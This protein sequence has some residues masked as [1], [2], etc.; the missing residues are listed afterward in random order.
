MDE[1]SAVSTLP[2]TGQTMPGEQHPDG[3]LTANL[4]RAPINRHFIGT[5]IL[6]TPGNEVDYRK[7][8]VLDT[9][10]ADR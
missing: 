6:C 5:V 10:M 1:R 8:T 3:V 7:T 2:E 9:F 4:P